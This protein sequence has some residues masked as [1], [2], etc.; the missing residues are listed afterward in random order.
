MAELVIRI[1]KKTDGD[2]VLS[3]S[4]AD[5]SV[6][7]L[8]SPNFPRKTQRCL[9]LLAHGGERTLRLSLGPRS[10]TYQGAPWPKLTSLASRS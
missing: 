10:P 3:C 6:T 7:C 9:K 1:K 2:A 5:G 8:P 4:R